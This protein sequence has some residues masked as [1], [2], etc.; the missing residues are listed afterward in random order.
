[1]LSKKRSVSP[2]WTL[3]ADLGWTGVVCGP[4][5]VEV[6]RSCCEGPEEDDMVDVSAFSPVPEVLVF[7]TG[8]DAASLRCLLFREM[9][10]AFSPVPE[11]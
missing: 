1:M 9:I 2:S 6:C 5:E 8:E 3:A 10:S 4:E 11:S 7:G